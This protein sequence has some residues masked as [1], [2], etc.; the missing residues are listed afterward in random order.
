M[1]TWTNLYFNRLNNFRRL[2]LRIGIIV[3][4]DVGLYFYAEHELFFSIARERDNIARERKMIARE[5]E[6]I[7]RER[8]NSREGDCLPVVGFLLVSFFK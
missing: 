1:N 5:R 8:E 6:M 3:E 7:A 2:I 4:C